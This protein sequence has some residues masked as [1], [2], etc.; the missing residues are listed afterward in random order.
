MSRS[1]QIP[2]A[3]HLAFDVL[4]EASETERVLIACCSRTVCRQYERAILARGGNLDNVTFRVVSP[5]ISD[6]RTPS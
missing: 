6:E 2:A 3:R 5:A 4:A 1:R